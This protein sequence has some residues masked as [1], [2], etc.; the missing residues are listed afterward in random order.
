MR[1]SALAESLVRAG[2]KVDILSLSGR[3]ADYKNFKASGYETLPRLQERLTEYVCRRPLPATLQSLSSKLKIPGLWETLW[4]THFSLPRHLQRCCEDAEVILINHPFLYPVFARFPEKIRVV[5]SH[6]LESEMVAHS[7]IRR[8]LLQKRI[9]QIEARAAQEADFVLACSPPEVEFFQRFASSPE[10]VLGVPNGVFIER[11]QPDEKRRR[12]VRESLDIADDAIAIIFLGSS[13][14]PNREAFEFLRNEI[15]KSE[16][17]LKNLGVQ[18]LAVGGVSRPEET[19]ASG[20]L[21]CFGRV[22]SVEPFLQSA[23]FAINPV[24]LGAGTNVKMFEYIAAHLPILTCAFGRRGLELKPFES[25]L[26]FERESFV[27]QLV[28]WQSEGL[29]KSDTREQLAAEAFAQNQHLIDM[30]VIGERVLQSLQAV[31]K[32]A[33][34]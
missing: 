23:D 32:S 7:P 16:E 21:R 13:Y 34:V 15:T 10:R 25:C 1:S 28:A 30:S 33:Y 12:H 14:G 19:L 22:E 27:D 18:V 29:F 26:E 2:A 17:K 11:Y 31:Q 8:S 20:V 6:N 4:S 24:E 3:L 5:C 9:A